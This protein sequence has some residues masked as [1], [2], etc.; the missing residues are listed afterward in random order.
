MLDGQ[1]NTISS[2]VEMAQSMGDVIDMQQGLKEVVEIGAD[3]TEVATLRNLKEGLKD[4]LTFLHRSA[5]PNAV[6]E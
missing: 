6:G 5:R 1:A 2:M 3:I 4:C